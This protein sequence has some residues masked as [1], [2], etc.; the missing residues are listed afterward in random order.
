VPAKFNEHYQLN[1]MRPA[2]FAT[3]TGTFNF[4][5]LRAMLLAVSEQCKWL[6]NVSNWTLGAAGAYIA[7]L[8]VQYDKLHP[9]LPGSWKQKIVVGIMVSIACG[10]LLKIAVG[11]AGFILG[12]TERLDRTLLP[13]LAPI[14]EAVRKSLPADTP[15]PQQELQTYNH[16]M[17]L[18]GPPFE[19]FIN[20]VPF[21]A[22]G[23]ARFLRRYTDKDLLVMFKIS[24]RIYYYGEVALLIQ[25]I[26]LAY[27]FLGTLW[28]LRY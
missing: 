26:T 9:H 23:L 14:E 2:D 21:F 28:H 11:F 8:L 27:A 10:V 7:L 15:R 19:E 13:L 3:P 17:T 1:P 18:I 24:A 12:L 5:V 4:Q 20:T 16:L 25:L 22:R 6:D